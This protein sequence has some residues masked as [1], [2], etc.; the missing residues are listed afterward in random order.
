MTWN[1]KLMAVRR[2]E[3]EQTPFS[4]KTFD[5]AWRDSPQKSFRLKNI[6]IE[7]LVYRVENSRVRSQL[8]E[9]EATE[10][11]NYRDQQ[12]TQE[13]QDRLGDILLKLAQ[14]ADGNGD[15]NVVKVLETERIQT[16]P[17]VITSS[18]VVVN[19][20]RRL[21]A[22][23]Y[24]YNR[25][26][27][28]YQSFQRASCV[29]LP[30]DALEEELSGVETDFQTKTNTRKEYGWIDKALLLEHQQVK[31]H[32][33]VQRI[34]Q[35]WRISTSKVKE[36]L[37][38]LAL[39]RE[40]LDFIGSPNQY[41]LAIGEKQS[42][43]SLASKQAKWIQD[44]ISPDLIEARK[45]TAWQIIRYD[46]PAHNKYKYIQIIEGVTNGALRRLT[47]TLPDPATA[48][49]INTGEQDDPFG[50]TASA[51]SNITPALRELKR[52]DDL[53]ELMEIL[54]DSRDEARLLGAEQDRGTALLRTT[55]E[56]LDD[57][58]HARFEGSFAQTH[59]QVLKNL[60]EIMGITLDIW[61]SLVASDAHLLGVVLS[62]EQREN[63]ADKLNAA[64]ESF[65]VSGGA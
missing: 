64:L 51:D 29:V 55:D 47:E 32:W 53:P 48:P 18:G 38:Q 61:N 15:A 43:V 12:E 46:G 25:D 1:L 65:E 16:Q 60:F 33:T 63:I 24:L 62:A 39:V 36:M 42:F 7:N 58:K 37:G 5:M 3:I 56:A 30:D 17:F 31:F 49:N 59:G 52:A 41:H 2:E 22:M 27:N 40:Y 21:A 10:H 8:L 14:D 4:G 13:A 34:C 19:G 28:T 54:R 26:S 11:V 35:Q 6:A 57:I 45:V 44:G 20:N 50:A 9:I 23:R